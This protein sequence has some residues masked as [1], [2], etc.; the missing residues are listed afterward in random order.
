M[1]TPDLKDFL[2]ELGRLKRWPSPRKQK[3]AQ[4]LALEFLITKFDLHRRYTEKEVNT[5]LN[6]SHTFG[7][8]ALLRRELI[9]AHLLERL[10]DGSAYWR[11]QAHDNV[12]AAGIEAPPQSARV[13]TTEHNAQEQSR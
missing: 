12:A 1:S 8:A 6:E 2:D 5:L 4:R 11:A 9:E 10:R 13:A 3:A 7:D